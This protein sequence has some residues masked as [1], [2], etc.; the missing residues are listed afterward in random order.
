M[1]PTDAGRGGVPDLSHGRRHQVD[2]ELEEEMIPFV[3]DTGSIS[4]MVALKLVEEWS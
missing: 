4:S 2:L 1:E 3:T